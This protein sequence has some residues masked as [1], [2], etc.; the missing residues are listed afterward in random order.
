[1]Y[2]GNFILSEGGGRTKSCPFDERIADC[3]TLDIKLG[4]IVNPSTTTVGGVIE[5]ATTQKN[6]SDSTLRLTQ[7]L[8]SAVIIVMVDV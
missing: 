3:T 8:F 5:H 7:Y 2:F 4:D 1:M 6:K